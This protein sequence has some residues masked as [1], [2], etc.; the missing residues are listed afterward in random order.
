MN[1]G[2]PYTD[3]DNLPNQVRK[4]SQSFFEAKQL[5]MYARETKMCRQMYKQ[6][7]FINYL[8][9]MGEL[10]ESKERNA[11][12]RYCILQNAREK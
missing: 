5:N 12:R 6:G 4:R 11:S 7:Q 3:N 9:R 8:L 10:T 2:D 1:T